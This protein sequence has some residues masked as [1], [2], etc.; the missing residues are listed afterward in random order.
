[1]KGKDFCD[2]IFTM[3]TTQHNSTTQGIDTVY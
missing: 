3:E 1:M 2:I